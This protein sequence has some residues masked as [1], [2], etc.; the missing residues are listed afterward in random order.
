MR[1]GTFYES[2]VINGEM[3]A[4]I[5]VQLVLE[6]NLRMSESMKGLRSEDESR[7]NGTEIQSEP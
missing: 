3:S 6:G 5:E 7:K 4:F 1:R 2:V